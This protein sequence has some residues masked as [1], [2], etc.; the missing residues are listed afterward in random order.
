M[1]D[2]PQSPD[3]FPR[4]KGWVKDSL[5]RHADWYKEAKECFG[6]VA[7]RSLQGDGQ[8]PGTSWQDMIDSGRQPVEFNRTGPIIDAICGMEV[9]NRQEVKYLPRT[10]GDTTVDERLTS[11]ADWARDETQAEDEESEMF[12]DAVICGRGATETR[13]DF[14]EEVTGKIVVDHLD[15]L[16]CGVDPASKKANFVNSRY[17]WRYRDIATDEAA[18]MFKG[19]IASALDASWA[20]TIDLTDG[21]EGNK[22]DY[23]DET[24]PALRDDRPLKQVRIVQIQWWEREPAYMV[25][26]PGAAEP[27]IVSAEEW[28][29]NAKQAA[30]NGITAEKVER[31][32]YYQAF[33]GR[34][35]VL[36]Q[37]EI[38]GFTIN[39]CTGRFDRNKGY[40]YG[41]VRPMRDPQMLANKTLSQVLHILNTNAKGGLIIEKG[42]FANPRDAERDWSDPS[43]TI[44]VNQGGMEK[45]KDRTAPALPVALVQMQEFSVSSIR[46]VTGVSVEMLGLADREQA[47]SLE[48]QRR[49]SAM[50][51]LASLFDSLRRYR[52]SQGVTMLQQLRKMPPGV[53][54]RV[55]IDPKEAEAIY[56]QQMQQWQ[57]AAQQAQQAGQQPPEQPKPVEEQFKDPRGEAFD[58]A[59]FGLSGEARFDVIVDEAPTSPNQKEGTWAAIQPFMANLPPNAVPIALKYSPLPESAAK[60]LGDAIAEAGQGPQIPPEV[61]QMAD[62]AQARIGELE[63]ENQRLKGDQSLKASQLEVARQDS[64]TRRLAATAKVEI[65]YA[66]LAHEIVRAQQQPQER[67]DAD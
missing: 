60:E 47:A 5:D 64:E 43:K 40:H 3:I 2:A 28:E 66:K 34:G 45:I 20:R 39:F 46:D 13:M 29:P 21:G 52:K 65:D 55:L 44:I 26:E 8:W 17:R 67:A 37:T 25:A 12:R 42:V 35:S 56:A 63:Q 11:L 23:P 41:V 4:L 18:A 7:G 24:R 49:Q 58:P 62:Q 15:P 48:Y 16:E 54:V 51:I 30:E 32:R 38:E 6:F 33:L 57:V 22:R 14:D 19:V 9:N 59:A 1:T 27:R 10:Q 61:Q 53:L 36:E 31:R 50:T